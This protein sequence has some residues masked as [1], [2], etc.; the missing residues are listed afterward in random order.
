[1]GAPQNHGQRSYKNSIATYNEEY[2]NNL[3]I[4]S[5]HF[6]AG[7]NLGYNYNEHVGEINRYNI[8]N[9]DTIHDPYTKL[10]TRKNYNHK[11]QFA[12]RDFW[13][14]DDNLYISNIAY[15]SVGKGGGTSLS[16]G[17]NNIN[18]LGLINLQDIYDNN[19]SFIDALYDNENTKSTSILRS[20][21]NN[22][23]WFGG[24][25]TINY[26]PN[27]FISLS[28]GLDY[29]S[30]K[31]EHYREVYDL[32]GGDYFVNESNQTQLNTMKY[33]GDKIDYHNDGI[34]NWKGGFGQVEI[35]NNNNLSGFINFSTARSKY[36]RIDYFKNMDL[37]LDD[38][39]ITQCLGTTK[40]VIFD[41]V[42]QT[43][44]VTMI[45]DSIEYNGTYY[46]QSSKYARPT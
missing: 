39:T 10:N 31:G 28:G 11:P 14:I 30:Y 13:N 3:D 4:D 19:I 5:S 20:S 24:L 8:L 18:E 37:V 34:I 7:F 16:S 21:V 15:A 17:Y 12:I 22:H 43:Y 46:T 44:S 42:T 1:M 23:Y 29:R 45:E 2:A 9:E 32:L 36:K 26:N 38:T 41:P 33:V 40:Q 35:D 25:S 27:D 6:P